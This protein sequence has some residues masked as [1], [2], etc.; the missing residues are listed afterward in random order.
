NG[1]LLQML[2]LDSLI[3]G[4]RLYVLRKR[5]LFKTLVSRRGE[6]SFTQAEIDEIEHRF[7]ALEPHLR[8]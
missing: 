8:A 4:V 1:K 3:P 6:Y 5:G 2:N 7:G